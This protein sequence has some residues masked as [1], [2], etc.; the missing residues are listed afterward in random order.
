M[1]V[2]CR[3]RNRNRNRGKNMINFTDEIRAQRELS[4]AQNG[5]R[6]AEDMARATLREKQADYVK[7]QR[8]ASHIVHP[9]T[10]TA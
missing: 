8:G 1:T 9:A 5:A 6:K 2:S 3:H 7:A 10:A 4:R